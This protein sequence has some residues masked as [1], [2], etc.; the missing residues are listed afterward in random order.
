MPANLSTRPSRRPAGRAASHPTRMETLCR[1][2]QWLEANEDFDQESPA[3]TDMKRAILVKI[4]DLE[5]LEE[6][7]SSAA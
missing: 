2:L 3:L 4:A 7:E 1:T 5:L 6:D